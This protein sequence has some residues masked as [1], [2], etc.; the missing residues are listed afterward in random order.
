MAETDMFKNPN[1]SES[2]ME[3]AQTR[4]ITFWKD[5]K[6]WVEKPGLERKLYEVR[7]SY[8]DKNSNGH[9]YFIVD[10]VLPI[11]GKVFPVVYS[12]YVNDNGTVQAAD[13]PGLPVN[14]V[15]HLPKCDNPLQKAKSAGA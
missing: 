11:V 12:V 3:N 15:R 10:N 1:S 8:T 6:G 2:A 13:E 9:F 14:Y 4:P 7:E 5:G